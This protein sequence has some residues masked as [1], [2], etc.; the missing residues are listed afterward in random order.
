MSQ[1]FHPTR[2]IGN[3]AAL[4]GS[5][6]V[7]GFLLDL[8][9]G[10]WGYRPM[11]FCTLIEPILAFAYGAGVL[12]TSVG[13]IIYAVSLF[14]SQAGIGLAVGGVMLFIVPLTLPHYL[15]VACYP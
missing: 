9:A 4:I 11:A 1:P 8:A 13:V 10:W 14:R 15:G 3:L 5:I 2:V 7:A 12:L 6:L